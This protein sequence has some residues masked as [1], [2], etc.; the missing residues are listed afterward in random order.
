LRSTVRA[1]C[2]SVKSRKRS[3]VNRQFTTVELPNRFPLDRYSWPI[4]LYFLIRRLRPEVIVETGVRYGVSTAHIGTGTIVLRNSA[5]SRDVELGVLA[6][7]VPARTIR[8]L[9]C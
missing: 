8:R 2:T 1:V 3:V 9:D 6:G 4:T 7:G 5:V